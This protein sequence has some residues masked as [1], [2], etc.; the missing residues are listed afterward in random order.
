MTIT[1]RFP[2]RC[3][4]CGGVIAV[5]QQIDWTRG[6]ASSHVTCPERPGREFGAHFRDRGPNSC[7]ACGRPAQLQASLGPACDYHYDDLS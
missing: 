6:G 1:A 4:R 5:G 7:M 3:S 2:G